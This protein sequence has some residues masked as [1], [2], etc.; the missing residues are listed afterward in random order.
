MPDWRKRVPKAARVHAEKVDYVFGFELRSCQRG[1]FFFR[2]DREGNLV[3]GYFNLEKAKL[4]PEE[5][6]A[7]NAALDRVKT[8]D[9]DVPYGEGGCDFEQ[10]YVP[11]GKRFEKLW[12]GLRGRP[13]AVEPFIRLVHGL[14]KAKFGGKKAA[15]FRQ[16]ALLFRSVE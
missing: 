6:K 16:S 5:L 14:V 11:A 15:D 2:V 7:F 1:D 12:I 3:L 10:Y 13:D 9:R 4:A 8:V